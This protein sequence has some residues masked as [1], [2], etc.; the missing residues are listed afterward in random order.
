[1]G[2]TIGDVGH[3]RESMAAYRVS[4]QRGTTP[5]ITTGSTRIASR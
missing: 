3:H 4:S 1:M 2:H 5:A